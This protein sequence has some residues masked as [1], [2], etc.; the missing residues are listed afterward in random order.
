VAASGTAS[1]IATPSP[2]RAACRLSDPL[3]VV[4][5]PSLASHDGA[6]DGVT[7]QGELIVKQ[8]D[9]NR[10]GAILTVLDPQTGAVEP[11]VSRPPAQSLSNARSQVGGA[12]GN[13]DWIVWVEQGFTLEVGD[14]VMWSMDRQTGKVR[15]IASFEPGTNGNAVPGW[16][17]AVSLLGNLATWS[18]DIEVP[19]SRLEPRIYVADLRAK[20]LR[21]LDTEARWPSLIATDLLAAAVA[22]G[23]AAGGKVLAQPATISI[24]DGKVTTQDWIEPARILSFSTSSSGTVITRLVKE[25]TA[26]EP[27]TLAE[28]VTHD[29]TI[30]TQTFA[31]PNEWGDVAAGTGFLTWLDQQHLWVLPSGQ[32]E[33]SKLVETPGD[34]VGVGMMA[35]GSTIYW[36][37]DTADETPVEMLASVACS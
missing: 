24:V 16:P 11:V 31:L 17:S 25:A 2:D 3:T 4:L 28:I 18:A 19:G 26:E 27:V 29:A 34:W 32:A 23:N 22:V 12:T 20:T 14:W 36:R 6:V 8:S 9:V 5:P 37:T 35:N 13:A 33:P 30:G 10:V 1:P 21:R 7:D 15:K